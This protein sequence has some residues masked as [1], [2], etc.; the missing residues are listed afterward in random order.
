MPLFTVQFF[1]NSSTTTDIRVIVGPSK[2]EW[3]I[4]FRPGTDKPQLVA[5]LAFIHNEWWNFS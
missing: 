1:G 5:A 4:L 2:A 3:N